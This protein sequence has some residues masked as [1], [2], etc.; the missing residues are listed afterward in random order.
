MKL[1]F[2][3]CLLEVIQKYWYSIGYTETSE[4]IIITNLLI[5]DQM[6]VIILFPASPV[7]TSILKPI[8]NLI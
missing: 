5:I 1:L 7:P 2:L 3:V 4:I 8:E 6:E